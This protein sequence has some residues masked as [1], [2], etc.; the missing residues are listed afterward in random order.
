MSPPPSR[1]HRRWERSGSPLPRLWRLGSLRRIGRLRRLLIPGRLRSLVR[2]VG[3]AWIGHRIAGV[4]HRRD[5][6]LAGQIGL[7]QGSI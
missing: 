5:Q 1:T 7:H 3:K 4:W 6:R 2:T